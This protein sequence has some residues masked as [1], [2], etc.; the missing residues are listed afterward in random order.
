MLKTDRLTLHLI[1]R[2]QFPE[3]IS[4]AYHYCLIETKNYL[5]EL[6][7][8]RPHISLAVDKSTPH[9]ETNHA[10]MILLPIKGK[11]VAVPID[12]PPVYSLAEGTGD[13]VGGEGQDLARQI[14][15]VLKKKLDFDESDMYYV[16][17]R[18]CQ[19]TPII[20]CYISV[21]L[22]VFMLKTD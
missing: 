10:V 21:A 22:A 3:I 1:H 15:D 17:G 6:T 4:A 5:K 20:G 8:L 7:G 2:N 9:R 13:V 18:Y 14:T 19:I 16:R 12:A 11:R